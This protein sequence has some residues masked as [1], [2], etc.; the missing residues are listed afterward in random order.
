[1]FELLIGITASFVATRIYDL[2]YKKADNIQSKPPDIPDPDT[3]PH[4][5]QDQ[6]FCDLVYNLFGELLFFIEQIS[7]LYCEVFPIVG[8]TE[9]EREYFIANPSEGRDH[10]LPE[11]VKFLYRNYYK[12]PGVLRFEND[13]LNSF[14]FKSFKEF[15]NEI[16]R[17]TII[18]S[19]DTIHQLFTALLGYSEDSAHLL[20]SIFE[21]IYYGSSYIRPESSAN[22]ANPLL[23]D[24]DGN[25]FRF[26]TV[27]Q[28]DRYIGTKQ[29][30]EILTKSK[31]GKI[32]RRLKKGDR[33]IAHQQILAILSV[34]DLL[35]RTAIELYYWASHAPENK[36]DDL[37]E[38]YE[39]KYNHCLFST[40]V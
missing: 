38:K 2:V 23:A 18:D 25:I 6:E 11:S 15:R 24:D 33:A 9:N 1:M 13:E 12:A 40:R 19:S 34:A 31:D 16:S 8:G 30:L 7:V 22:A 4:L 17:D 36:M 5:A 10:F 28:S 3:I 35:K 32:K 37:E 21:T 14:R 20:D 39:K 29:A 27:A 26:Y